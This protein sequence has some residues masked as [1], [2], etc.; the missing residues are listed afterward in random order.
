MPK[1]NLDEVIASINKKYGKELIYK[2]KDLQLTEVDRITTGSLFL[3]KL[4]GT[5]KK[6]QSGWPMGRIVEL[7]GP[8]MSGKSS[9]CMKTIASAQK[10]GMMCAWFDVEKSFEADRAEALGVD[11][12]KLLLNQADEDKNGEPVSGESIL[13][14]VCDLLKTKQVD[15]IVVDSLASLVPKAELEKSLD[16]SQRMALAASMMSQALRKINTLN[17]K[18]LII[19][20]NQLRTNPGTSY[21]NPEYTPGGKALKYYSSVRLELRTGEWIVEN[22][23]KIG[24]IVKFK[25]AKNKTSRPHEQGMFQFMYTGEIDQI[26]EIIS[27]G[28]LTGAIKRKGAY[29]YLD[30]DTGF[31]GRDD[32]YNSLKKDPALFEKAKKIVFTTN[33]VTQDA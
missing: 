2:A 33:E 19:F 20:I 8:E 1:S 13:E 9:L 32:M 16:D 11:T 10:Q 22:K 15:V 3:D 25:I 30:A 6:K 21:G 26:D 18:T 28:E 29:Y 12:Q 7:Y 27:V 31:H 24:Q 4:L 17:S 14:I 23:Q 5:N